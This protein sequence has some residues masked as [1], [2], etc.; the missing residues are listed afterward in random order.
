MPRAIADSDDED[1]DIV[2]ASKSQIAV[3][4]ESAN[5][6]QMDASVGVITLDR[7]AANSTGS[8]GKPELRFHKGVRH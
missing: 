5:Q 1:D 7:A 8:T 4:E 2:V 3:V 6:D